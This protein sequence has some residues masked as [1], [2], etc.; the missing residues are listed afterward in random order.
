MSKYREDILRLRAEGYSYNRI[1]EELGCTKSTVCYYLGTDQQAKTRKRSY[2]KRDKI[3]KYLQEYKQQQGCF[4]CKEKYPYW[5]LEFDHLGD[6]SFT[7]GE[8]RNHTVSL[9]VIKAEIEKCD[10]VCANCHK[11]RTYKR[12]VKSGTNSLD[13]S[14]LYT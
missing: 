1:V 8:F 3:T 14:A 2:D 4:D 7:I 9:D 13:I 10:V 11:N 6:K 5:I 12:A